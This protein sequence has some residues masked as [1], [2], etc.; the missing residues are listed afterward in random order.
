MSRVSSRK[1]HRLAL[2]SLKGWN[3]LA[4]DE[5]QRVRYEDEILAEEI[6]KVGKGKLAIGEHLFNLREILGAKNHTGLWERYLRTTPFS[7]ATAN[8]YIRNFEV[9][10][11]ILPK[12]IFEVAMLRGM[13][14]LSA[15][16]IEATP[17]PNTHNPVL[18]NNYLDRIQR[19][20][21]IEMPKPNTEDILRVT[22]NGVRLAYAKVPNRAREGFL[23]RLIGMEM[24]LGNMAAQKFEP[25]AIPED[26][27]VRVG[28]PAREAA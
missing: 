3:K 14:T 18:I 15:K 4:E 9:T 17:P 16:M 23:T 19:T 8:R 6:E 12:P 21:V 25:E 10:R 1:S 28:R 24:S 2:E 22:Y 26:F 5:Q 11:T 7:R 27:V 13:D 20:P